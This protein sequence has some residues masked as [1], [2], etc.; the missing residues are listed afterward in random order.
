MRQDE[1]HTAVGAHALHHLLGRDL[2]AYVNTHLDAYESSKKKWTECTMNEWIA[3]ADG[4]TFTLAC[5]GVTVSV[6]HHTNCVICRD[7]N[8]ICCSH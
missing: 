7:I 8:K 3:G 2:D 5:L 6:V 1:A 4:I